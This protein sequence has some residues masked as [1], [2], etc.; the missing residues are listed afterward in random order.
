[1]SKTIAR[2]KYMVRL[3]TLESKKGPSNLDANASQRGQVLVILVLVLAVLLTV[4]LSVASRSVTE[5]TLTSFEENA[6]RAF[7]AAEA[8]VEQALLNP[9]ASNE[10]ISG[11]T[12]PGVSFKT[13]IDDP[14]VS[15][16]RFR[17]P[18]DLRPG[19]TATFWLV[20]HDDKTGQLVCDPPNEPCFAGDSFKIC[21]STPNLPSSTPAVEILF[22]YDTSG[23]AVGKPNNFGNVQVAKFAVDPEQR[24]NNF[25][26]AQPAN[27]DCDF[28]QD[29]LD[30]LDYKKQIDIPSISAGCQAQGCPLLVKVRM[31]YNFDQNFNPIPHGLGIVARQIGP[32][33]SN[34]PNQ[35][36]QITSTGTA[37]E[38]TRRVSVFQ[39]YPE[40]PSLFDAAIFSKSGLTK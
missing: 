18:K 6:L 3:P 30:D 1:M 10:P 13:T 29:G 34:L 19:E 9:V 27:G 7:S 5:V 26:P 16:N 37:G 23:R 4:V 8:G 14:Y 25:E 35:G 33:G 17:Y 32:Q 12:E 21:W 11:S 24:N 39:S 36:L 2:L 38:S 31:Y 15:E 20:S 40:P 22:F 28:N